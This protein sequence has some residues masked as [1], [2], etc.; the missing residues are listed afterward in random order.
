MTNELPGTVLLTEVDY[1]KGPG[2]GSIVLE[3]D[4][5]AALNLL[6]TKLFK[7]PNAEP[8]ID[9]TIKIMVKDKSLGG[10]S[11]AFEIG[12]RFIWLQEQ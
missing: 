4:G 9:G 6:S 10:Y 5:I 3:G 11:R 7:N 2:F 12:F 1:R 8:W